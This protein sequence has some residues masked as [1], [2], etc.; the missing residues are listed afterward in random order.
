MDVDS[1]VLARVRGWFTLAAGERPMSP[2][3]LIYFVP[4]VALVT[5]GGLA[6]V[7]TGAAPRGGRLVSLAILSYGLVM[8][9]PTLQIARG[10]GTPAHLL[11]AALLAAPSN[12]LDAWLINR[13]ITWRPNLILV[14]IAVGAAA[15]G[16]WS[17]YRLRHPAPSQTRPQPGRSRAGGGDSGHRPEHS[18]PDVPVAVPVGGAAAAGTLEALCDQLRSCPAARVSIPVP[19]TLTYGGAD[20][21]EQPPGLVEALL[22]DAALEAGLLPDGITPEAG[23]RLFHYRRL[24]LAARHP[25]TRG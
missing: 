21:T 12:W 11:V 17:R 24:N 6:G 25:G 3:V 2:F 5:V 8:A 10:R 1:G 22:Q 13:P 15:D 16:A 23:G 14:F 4:V 20:V 18:A 19:A 9:W 7:V